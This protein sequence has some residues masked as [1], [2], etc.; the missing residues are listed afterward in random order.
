VRLWRRIGADAR[1][2][3]T[4]RVVL[5]FVCLAS[6]AGAH[7]TDDLAWF[8][9]LAI[10]ILFATVG[11]RSRNSTL[12]W[13]V[14][15]GAVAGIAV[16]GSGGSSSP[17]LPYL[18]AA[19]AA[20]AIRLGELGAVPPSGA[21]AVALLLGPLRTDVGDFRAYSAASAEWVALSLVV[22]LAVGR[23][24]SAMISAPDADQ[25]ENYA[26]AHRLLSQLRTVA[27]QLSSGLDP[28]TLSEGLLEA[29]RGVVDFDKGAV[30]G[31][32]PGGH[33]V[34][35]AVL[36]ADRIDWDV[37][38]SGDNAF[39]EAWASQRAVVTTRAHRQVSD[40]RRRPGS[41]VADPLRAGVRTIGIVGLES[42]IPWQLDR[43]NLA[44]LEEV[45]EEFGVRLETALLFD[46]VREVATVEERRRL[47]REIH[48]GIA[49]ELASLGYVIDT[50]T[51]ESRDT[52]MG[53]QL[54]SLRNELTRIISEIRL[55][56]FDLRSEVD[57]FGG[58][59]AALG[60]Y[61]R[62]V[63]TG[64][65]LRVHLSLDEGPARLPA[66]TEAELLRI[67]QE[68]ITN[69]RK[70][71]SARN[72]WVNCAV[73]P[74]SALLRVEDDGVGLQSRREDSFGIE[75]MRERAAR[76]RAR[77]SIT[78]RESGGTIVEVALGSK[79]DTDS[80]TASQEG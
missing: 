13:G 57:Q 15:D 59:G 55:S 72:L 77:L 43:G 76:L 80:V 18:I 78:P 69:A 25:R 29:M 47:A 73:E 19:S 30:Y 20:T 31:R 49:Q 2:P 45:A 58:L 1:I 61:V 75:I 41:S 60:E 71:A 11:S 37:T 10:V 7:G 21:S 24:R 32:S 36:G 67:A 64:S 79:W 39:A 35:L 28:V 62:S 14:V 12:A 52:A 26:A 70:H 3:L 65:Q 48:D 33:L 6:A 22:G 27:R 51:A 16:V 4:I 5:F 34:P 44:A 54:R 8:A 50:M 23:I 40:G 63:G 66:E 74:P 53:D 9:P 38:L 56:I 68:A 42:S 46:E 17:V